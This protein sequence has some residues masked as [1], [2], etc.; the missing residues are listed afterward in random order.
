MVAFPL[1]FC[2]KR[3]PMFGGDL[4]A[5]VEVIKDIANRLRY[6]L[7]TKADSM[8]NKESYVHEVFQ[9]ILRSAS[10]LL[11]P[12]NLKHHKVVEKLSFKH[13]TVFTDSRAAWLDLSRPQRLKVAAALMKCL[14]EHSFLLANVLQSPEIILEATKRTGNSLKKCKG[15]KGLLKISGCFY[16]YFA[17]QFTRISCLVFLQRIAKSDSTQKLQN[18]APECPF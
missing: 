16:A 2:R 7:Q 13:D 3:S 18:S 1:F 10:N 5:S 4:E 9:N 17:D 11:S 14:E 12:G 6:L 8:Y 15:I